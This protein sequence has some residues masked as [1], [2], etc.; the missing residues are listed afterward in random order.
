MQLFGCKRSDIKAEI[1]Q[2]A[3][4]NNGLKVRRAPHGPAPPNQRTALT[5]NADLFRVVSI[6]ARSARRVG[7]TTSTDKESLCDS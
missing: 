7:R 5:A 3:L 2:F 6:S 4:Q 1:N